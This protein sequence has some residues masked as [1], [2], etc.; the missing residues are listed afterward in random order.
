MYYEDDETRQDSDFEAA[1]WLE[2]EESRELDYPDEADHPFYIPEQLQEEEEEEEYSQEIHE[3]VV[4]YNICNLKRKRKRS[5]KI[6]KNEDC[7]ICFE[8]LNKHYVYC[9]TEC[10]QTFHSG[11]V[12]NLKK[13]PVCRTN[14]PDWIPCS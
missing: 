7:P 11:C 1:G 6:I 9:S 14:P 5:V 10:G 3:K 13:C 8:E 12:S 4:I 2:D